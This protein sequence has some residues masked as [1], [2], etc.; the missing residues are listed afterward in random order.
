MRS[1]A[2]TYDMSPER[3][4]RINGLRKPRIFPGQTLLL[5]RAASSS[6]SSKTSKSSKASGSS[7]SSKAAKTSKKRSGASSKAS[8]R[9]K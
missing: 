9:T 7:K 5:T 6:K 3:L 4:M 2:A 8:A 1:I